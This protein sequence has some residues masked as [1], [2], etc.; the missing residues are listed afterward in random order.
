MECAWPTGGAAQPLC[1]AGV[2]VQSDSGQSETHGTFV[3]DDEPQDGES[4]TP[5]HVLPPQPA[6]TQRYVLYSFFSLCSLFSL[7]SSIVEICSTK[8]TA[9]FHYIDA[10]SP[11]L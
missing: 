11:I 3:Q 9:T 2:S 8:C 5:A 6:F 4:R 10:L 7:I 1:G